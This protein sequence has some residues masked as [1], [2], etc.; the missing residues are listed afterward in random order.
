MILEVVDM[1]VDKGVNEVANMVVDGAIFTDVTMVSE[2]TYWR[3]WRWR[4]GDGV[5]AHGGW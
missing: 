4:C 3:L 1:D 2:D 5:G